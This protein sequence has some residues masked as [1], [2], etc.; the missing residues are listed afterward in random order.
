MTLK[1]I[2]KV[3]S[4]DLLRSSLES[5]NLTGGEP[6]LR[7]DL[8]QI[9]EVIA[10]NCPN[11]REISLN[12]N[13]FLTERL[14]AVAKEILAILGKSRKLNIYISLDGIGR[15]H[16]QVRGV[17]NAFGRVD[18]SLKFLKKL[19]FSYPNLHVGLNCT[20]SK[21][22]I[23]ELS[24]VKK[25]G[26]KNDLGIGYTFAQRSDMYINSEGIMSSF[27]LDSKDETNEAVSF[28]ETL[29]KNPHQIDISKAYYKGLARQIRGAERT[30]PCIFQTSGFFMEPNGNISPCG[31]SRSLIWGNVREKSFSTLWGERTEADIE[32]ILN[33]CKKCETNCYI[34]W[35]DEVRP[36]VDRRKAI[37]ILYA[38]CKQIKLYKILRYY[39]KRLKYR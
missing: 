36:R 39:Y 29:I 25:Y 27:R 14:V 7:D 30:L 13:G 3:F 19:E 26:D 15:I 16:D 28:L 21:F 35:N 24:L 9:A 11:L 31:V 18:K 37:S 1:Q 5:V 10:N 33:V 32:K 6:T 38:R 23:K 34:D 8:A 12:T 22:N 20:I 2:K 17:K 4:D